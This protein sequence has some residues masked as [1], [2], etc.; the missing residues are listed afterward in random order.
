MP[1]SEVVVSFGSSVVALLGGGGVVLVAICAF[2]SQF[3]TD[4]TIEGHKATL[5]AELERLKNELAKESELH[6]LKLRKAEILFDRELEAVAEFGTLYRRITPRYSHPDMDW[7][8]ACADV[9]SRFSTIEEQLENYLTKHAP[10]LSEA[11]REKLRHCKTT[12]SH[13]KFMEYE[14]PEDQATSTTKAEAGRLLEELQNVESGLFALVRN[15]T[16]D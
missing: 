5:N 7:D 8:D 3:I 11:L 13:N 1:T 2:I 6:K 16:R 10:V 12:A 14:M 15:E 4:R 9:A